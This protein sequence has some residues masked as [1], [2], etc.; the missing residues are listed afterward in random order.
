VRFLTATNDIM[1]GEGKHYITIFMTARVKSDKN[2]WQRGE[3]ELPVAKLLEPEKCAGWEWAS[4]EDLKR[5]TG[6]QIRAMED[7]G[8]GTGESGEDVRAGEKR[9]LFSPMISLLVQRPDAVPRLD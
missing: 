3:D 7:Q 9:T 8:K 1:P 2:E 6:P 4:W 5:W